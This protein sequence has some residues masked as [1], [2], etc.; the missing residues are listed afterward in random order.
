MP[1]PSLIAVL[2]LGVLVFAFDAGAGEPPRDQRVDYG[3]S[4]EHPSADRFRFLL[5]TY[6]EPFVPA[7]YDGGTLAHEG[8]IR[9][10]FSFRTIESGL[11]L[12]LMFCA[13]Q[14]DCITVCKSNFE[15]ATPHSMCGVNG[16]VAFAASGDNEDEVD[17]LVSH[18]AGAE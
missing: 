5:N 18:F 13:H 11:R 8:L 10:R 12:M 4:F 6:R 1:R 7:Q 16:A 17:W 9:A 2:S 14:K 3:H 15:P